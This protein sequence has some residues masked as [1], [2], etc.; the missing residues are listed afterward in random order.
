MRWPGAEAGDG[1]RY[2]ADGLLADGLAPLS[3]RPDTVPTTDIPALLPC[4]ARPQGMKAPSLPCPPAK[5]RFTDIEHLEFD[6]SHRD[7]DA[8]AEP[9]STSASG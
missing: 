6:L 7:E 3:A 9:R 4:P 5:V 1:R 8:R 2:S